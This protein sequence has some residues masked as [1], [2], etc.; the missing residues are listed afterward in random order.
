MKNFPQALAFSVAVHVLVACGLLLCPSLTRI[1]D[2]P[3]M[4]LSAVEFMTAQDTPKSQEAPPEPQEQ[5]EPPE[6]EPQEPQE[7]EPQEQQEQP[8][9]QDAP[10]PEPQ[11]PPEISLPEPPEPQEPPEPPEISLPEPPEPPP[12]PPR[13]HPSPTPEAP[14]PPAPPPPKAPHSAPPPPAAAENTARIDAPPR[15]ARPIRPEYP[16]EARQRGEEGDV[17]L[18]LVITARG[19]VSEV[20]VAASSGFRDLDDAAARAAAR[21]KFKPATR[22]STPVQANARIIIK[23]RI[24]GK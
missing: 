4:E 16:K 19:L 12:E 6:P 7:P 10:P 5:Q 14:P 23:F 11:E 22:G 13:K 3:Q 8:E 24:S 2:A 21:T 1:P 9:P 18:D 15:A 17:T 20:S